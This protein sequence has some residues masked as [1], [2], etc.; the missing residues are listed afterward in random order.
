MRISTNTIYQL[1]TSQMTALQEKISQTSQQASTG[2]K[3]MTPQDDPVGSAKL[4]EA[5]QAISINDQYAVNRNA[6]K[7]TIGI[8]NVALNGVQDVMQSMNEQIVSLGN[9]IL[10][11]SNRQSIAITLQSQ[12]DHL[13][14]LSNTKDAAGHYIFSGY[15]SDTASIN[16][17]SYAYGGDANNAVIQVDSSTQLGLGVNANT[18]FSSGFLAQIKTSITA[19]SN[20]SSTDVQIATAISELSVAFNASQITI[21]AAQV[22]LGTSEN[23]L[24]SMDSIGSERALT[25]KDTVSSLEDVD[26][27]K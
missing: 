4:L 23:R 8:A 6:L 27:K 3:V 12:L 13:V 1:S 22:T 17:S 26:Y 25:Y 2:K 14:T 16:A 24:T 7:Y 15:K 18:M 21:N 20:A 5:K 11:S 9:G 10:N 19:L